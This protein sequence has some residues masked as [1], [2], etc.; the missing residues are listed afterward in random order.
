LVN[1]PYPTKEQEGEG[2]LGGGSIPDWVPRVS[3]TAMELERR[4]D[5]A[6]GKSVK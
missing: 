3:V 6:D 2:T 5:G 1:D 4:G